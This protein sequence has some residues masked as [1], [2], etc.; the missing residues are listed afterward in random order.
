MKRLSLTELVLL[1][2]GLAALNTCW[3]ALWVRWLT[4]AG[5]LGAEPGVS[6]LVM[7]ITLIAGVFI[8]RWAVAAA[9]N[10]LELQQ[11]QR[12]IG[13]SGL[14]AVVGVL[15]LTFGE[16]FPVDYFRSFTE[17]GRL[18]SAEALA[19]GV[20]VLLWWRAI[21]IGRDDDL[22]S[23]ARREFSGGVLALAALFVCNKINPQLATPEAFWPTLL[24]FAIGLGALALAGFEQ[25]R[26]IQTAGAGIGLGLSRGWL[27]TV[28]AIIGCIIAGATLVVVLVSPD[29]IAGLDAQLDA[30][31]VIVIN[32]FGLVIYLI[33]VALLP[34]AEALVRALL[35]LLHLLA[36]LS[37]NFKLN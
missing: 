30:V 12:L 28:G 29:S 26:R 9:Q 17:W 16:R 24:F 36:G 23:S 25:D 10:N 33:A 4:A 15:W 3:L 31:G 11:P 27:G 2:V 20:A 19:L 13:F 8:T 5:D 35:P 37:A 18:V 14:A 32:L 1:P 34:V 22:H 21:R 7:L 6:P